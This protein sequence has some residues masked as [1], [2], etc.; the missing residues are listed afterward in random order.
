MKYSGGNVMVLRCK[1]WQ[2]LGKHQLVDRIIDKY[3][4]GDI[5]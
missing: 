4:Y 2:V 5:L 1:S 3:Q